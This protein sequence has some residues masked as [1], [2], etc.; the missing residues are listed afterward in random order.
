MW[1][2]RVGGRGRFRCGCVIPATR[3]GAHTVR[4]ATLCSSHGEG[5]TLR[6]LFIR[7]A[8]GI[9]RDTVKALSERR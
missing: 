7:S 5:L 6:T 4:Y 9:V 1:G 3:S 2:V 8:I